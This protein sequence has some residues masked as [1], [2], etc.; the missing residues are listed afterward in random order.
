MAI[1]AA[2]TEARIAALD[3]FEEEPAAAPRPGK[4]TFAEWLENLWILNVLVFVAG[5]TYFVLSGFQLNISSMIM[6]FTSPSRF[7]I[8]S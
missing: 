1:V 7:S 4:R 2:L 8:Q 5:I 6:L 3:V